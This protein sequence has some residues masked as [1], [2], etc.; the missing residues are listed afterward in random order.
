MQLGENIRGNT[1]VK[2]YEKSPVSQGKRR[3]EGKKGKVKVPKSE[4]GRNKQ[5]NPEE[6]KEKGQC[7]GR[8][9]TMIEMEHPYERVLLVNKWVKMTASM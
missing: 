3:M 9:S 2:F 5:K 6:M 4:S 7:S 1:T 8:V